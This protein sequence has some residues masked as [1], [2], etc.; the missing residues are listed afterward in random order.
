VTLVLYFFRGWRSGW[1][2]LTRNISKFADIIKS[3]TQ[4]TKKYLPRVTVP[5]N[6]SIDEQLSALHRT[7]L[8]IR[9]PDAAQW[10]ID[11]RISIT[12]HRKERGW[13][14]PW[15]SGTV[16]TST[17]WTC[18]PRETA[19]SHSVSW[20]TQKYTPAHR[21]TFAVFHHHTTLRRPT[22]SCV[23]KTRW[24]CETRLNDKRR[25][26]ATYDYNINNNNKELVWYTRV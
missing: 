13:S 22:T 15:L 19:C 7:A 17:S 1:R 24:D 14:R 21:H 6:I 20:R 3:Q 23:L 26:V 11:R 18:S 25:R 2:I 16:S 4:R 9:H 5:I 10:R 12:V 8:V